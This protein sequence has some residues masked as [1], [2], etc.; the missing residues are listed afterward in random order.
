MQLVHLLR[1][2]EVAGEGDAGLLLDERAAKAA[3]VGVMCSDG[4]EHTAFPLVEIED[5]GNPGATRQICM[6]SCVR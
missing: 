2:Q 4:V 3:A 5:V 6:C 1:A